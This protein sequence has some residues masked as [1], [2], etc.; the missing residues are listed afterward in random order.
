M[1]SDTVA[2]NVT[3]RLKDVPWD[4]ALDIILEAKASARRPSG[5]RH[6]SLSTSS[7]ST[8][9]PRMERPDA[10]ASASFASASGLSGS[11]YITSNATTSAPARKIS[12][13]ASA[14]RSRG[15]GHRPMTSSDPSS[16]ATRAMRLLS[17]SGRHRP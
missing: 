4:Q 14:W 5:V 9:V 13:T 7:G 3:L 10:T 15:H 17:G 16:I 2:G 8:L 6:A 11:P 1:T 12:R